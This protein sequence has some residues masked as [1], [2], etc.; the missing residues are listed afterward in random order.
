LYNRL[1]RKF[2]KLRDKKY[3][4]A[5]VRDHIRIGLPYQIRALREQEDRQWTQETLAIKAGKHQNVISRIEDPDYG[6][7]SLQTLMDLASAF[8]VALIVK[9][10]PY[11][12][13]L[14]EFDDVSPKS[15]EAKGFETECKLIE[16]NMTAPLRPLP[17]TQVYVQNFEFS[18]NNTEKYE[19]LGEPLSLSNVYESISADLA[20]AS[21]SKF[22]A[23]TT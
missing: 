10:V 8:D 9:F 1:L 21:P 6:K 20:V 12:R 23:Q 15:L 3:R 7:L 5:Y 16:E 11:S 13:F 17:A 2:N 14:R 4:D 19:F 22:I 18:L